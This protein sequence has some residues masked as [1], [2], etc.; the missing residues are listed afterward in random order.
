MTECGMAHRYGCSEARTGKFLMPSR[1]LRSCG[2]FAVI[3][4]ETRFLVAEMMSWSLGK[5][6][7]DR[8]G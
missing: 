2:Q 4:G 6:R 3:M 1:A 7:Q 8:S 5:W